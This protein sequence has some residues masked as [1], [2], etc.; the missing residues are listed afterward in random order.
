[1][2]KIRSAVIALP[3]VVALALCGT[4]FAGVSSH[5]GATAHTARGCG[6]TSLAPRR[7]NIR[8]IAR[9]T[10]CLIN[11][12]RAIHGLRPLRNNGALDRV[13]RRHSVDMVSHGYFSHNTL[14]GASP[15]SRILG[16]GYGAGRRVCT[17][18][19]NIAAAS[20][21]ATPATIVNMWMNSPDHRANILDSAYRDS[22]VGVAIG[23]PGAR[24]VRGA[25]F[26]QDFGRRC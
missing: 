15:F 3:G 11:R 22:G 18:G 7:S 19:E 17:M 4:S 2:L 16:S 21:R 10:L 6:P 12:Q 13:A 9:I 8:Q 24:G 5:A 23:Y 14:Q 26:T 20:G 1:M 25:T